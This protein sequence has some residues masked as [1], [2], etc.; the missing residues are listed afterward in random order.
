MR[1]ARKRP[2]KR[3]AVSAIIA[4]VT[5][6]AVTL[7]SCLILS[8]IFYGSFSYYVPPAEVAAQ[9]SSCS[10]QNGNEVCQLTL[11][12]QS[13]HSVSTSSQCAMNVQGSRLTGT[14]ANGGTVPGS[15]TLAGVQCVVTG[16]SAP[17]GAQ[18][19][20]TLPLM[21]Y[22]SVIFTAISS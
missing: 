3:R 12:N 5:L 1:I 18:I 8:G 22:A 19:T 16:A 9:S 20:G 17:P 6:I 15:G 10:A 7:I 2:A 4:E 14:V 13:P 21:N 11:Q